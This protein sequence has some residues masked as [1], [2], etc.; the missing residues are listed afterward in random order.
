[1]VNDEIRK[2]WQ[3]T[4][5]KP[6]PRC[7]DYEFIRRA[8]LDL[9][10]RIARP[11]EIGKFLNEPPA[12]RRSLLIERLLDSEEYAKN[13]SNIWTVWL[14]TRSGAF[15]EGLKDHHEQM[16]LWVEEQFA[17]K[18][19]R[20]DKFVTDLLTASGKTNEN[21]AVNFILAHLG[22]PNR[23]DPMANGKY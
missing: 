5:I 13:W 20:F 14:M 3:E 15:D 18:D 12:K 17:N 9:I 7:T 23:D 10:G 1:Y 21:Q 11:S 2:K 8:C 6:S 22:E 19:L 4:K 16:Q